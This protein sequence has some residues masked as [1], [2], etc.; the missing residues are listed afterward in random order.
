MIAVGGS[1]P[2]ILI[3]LALALALPGAARAAD[4][5]IL[6]ADGRT[7]EGATLKP[8]ASPTEV[9][10][11]PASGAPLRVAAQDLLVVD[12][13]KVP[14]RELPPS[15]RLA[16]GDQVFGKITFPAPNRV[17]IAAGWGSLTVPLNWCVG[18]RLQEK[19]PF[20]PPVKQDTVFL[21]NDRVEGQV[22]GFAGGKITF[23]LSGKPVTLGLDRVQA[24]ALA[25][26][27][28]P[29]EPGGLLLGLDLGGGERLTGRWV[30]L[31][32]DLLTI[33]ADWGENVDVPVASI[34]RL[35]VRN[36][37]L[38][39]L[40]ALKPSESRFTPFVDGQYPY[41]TDRS[42]AGTPLRLAGKTYPRGLGVHSRTELTY[43]LDGGYQTF[44]AVLGIDDGVVGAGSVVFRVFG[45]E[46]L[47]F[48]SAVVRGGDAPLDLKLAVKGVLLLRL[49]VDYGDQG[50]AADHANWADARL[51]RP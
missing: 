2:R 8:G 26:R 17:K 46:K 43:A 41:R 19:A 18:L 10:V 37:K 6:L 42:V 50:D 16:N 3:A 1:M 20:P 39:Y 4:G 11:E 49:E 38:V 33:R 7:L 35:E 22:Q 32:E 40:S 51:L 25:P 45:D 14:T 44:A 12:F 31:G 34:A 29:A 5:Q 13:G 9:V 36:G 21:N 28:R 27:A 15:V 47:L 48:E 23:V 24:V 30:K